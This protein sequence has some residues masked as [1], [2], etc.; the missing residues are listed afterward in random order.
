MRNLAIKEIVRLMQIV[1]I[2]YD[3]KLWDQWSNL[4]LLEFYGKLRIEIET[5]EYDD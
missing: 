5:E 3:I 4:E 2:N 1:P